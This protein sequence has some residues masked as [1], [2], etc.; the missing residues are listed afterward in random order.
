M[1]MKT[2][3]LNEINNQVARILCVITKT[4]LSV[5]DQLARMHRANA[6]ANHYRRNAADWLKDQLSPAELDEYGAIT[7]VPA[8]IYAK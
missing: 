7:S 4:A 5:P 1:T 6:I 2:K 3:T 8:S